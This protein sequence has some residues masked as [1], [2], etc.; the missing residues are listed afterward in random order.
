MK[1][2]NK[3]GTGYK[4]YEHIILGYE[5]R[6]FETPEGRI[7]IGVPMGNTVSEKQ[8][9]DSLVYYNKNV[10]NGKGDKMKV[11]AKVR[12]FIRKWEKDN[13]GEVVL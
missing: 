7:S 11:V 5:C 1:L 4:L 13:L 10:Y 9:F 12:D 6:I 8:M 3:T 2:L